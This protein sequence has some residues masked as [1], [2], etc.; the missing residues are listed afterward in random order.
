MK[1]FVNWGN[2]R[3]KD[4]GLLL[5]IMP[6][7]IERMV[8]PFLGNGDALQQD[9]LV[10]NLDHDSGAVAVF[11]YLG[12]AMAH[13]LQYAQC[14]IDQIVT[15]VAVYVH[16][17]AHTA[18]VMLIL[19]LIKSFFRVLKF[20]FCHIILVYSYDLLLFLVQRYI[21]MIEKGLV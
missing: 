10:G 7:E 6:E 8:V 16:Y 18:G 14:L 20:T 12:T 2:G 4:F 9:E 15:L 17:H 21:K 3:E 19:A 13:V 11:A 1:T 5:P